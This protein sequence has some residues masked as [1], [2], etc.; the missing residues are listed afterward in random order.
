MST[1][2]VFGNSN[3]LPISL[4]LSLSMTISGLHWDRIPGDNDEEVGARGILYLL[5]FQQ[6]GQHGLDDQP[7]HRRQ[8]NPFR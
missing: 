3:S 5:I 8:E 1:Q 7:L 4:V 6:L 2:G